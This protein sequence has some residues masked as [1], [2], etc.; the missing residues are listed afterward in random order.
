M[1]SVLNKDYT[2]LK[3]DYYNGYYKVSSALNSEVIPKAFKEEVEAD[4]LEL[5]IRNQDKGNNFNDV[6]DG[7][8][9]EFIRNIVDVYL[10]E[11]STKTKVLN[12]I[13]YGIAISGMFFGID[14]LNNSKATIAS[15]IMAGVTLVLV[16][17]VTFSNYKLSKK[18]NP[19]NMKYI[20]GAT[21]FGISLLSNFFYDFVATLNSSLGNTMNLSVALIIIIVEVVIGFY[22]IKKIDKQR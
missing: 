8:I 14:I 20:A 4:I 2:Y 11:T 13:G 7:D 19:K 16:A 21:G 10:E 3:G 18:V 9:D 15:L 6:V 22:I 17:L 5:F 1:E 12:S